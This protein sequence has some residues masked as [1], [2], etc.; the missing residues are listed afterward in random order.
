MNGKKNGNL[1][2]NRIKGLND[3]RNETGEKTW[4]RRER[5]KERKKRIKA[6]YPK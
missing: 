3:K 6:I 5:E 2:N 4:K 1:F